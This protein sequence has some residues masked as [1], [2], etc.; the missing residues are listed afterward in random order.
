[1]HETPFLSFFSVFHSE[2]EVD[3]SR[4]HLVGT[5]TDPVL[6]MALFSITEVI[7]IGACKHMVRRKMAPIIYLTHLYHYRPIMVSCHQ[8]NRMLKYLSYF[9]A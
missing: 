4:A 2:I 7:M 3:W 9:L 6:W 1:M 5:V 8:V